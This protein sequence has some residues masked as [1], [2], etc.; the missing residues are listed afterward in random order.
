[1]AAA[2]PGPRQIALPN[3]PAP[4]G[5]IAQPQAGGMM[6]QP[7]NGVGQPDA[8]GQARFPTQRRI[9]II[10]SRPGQ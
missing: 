2:A 7:P 5:P 6:P 8:S 4:N 10:P 3:I 9:R 1:M